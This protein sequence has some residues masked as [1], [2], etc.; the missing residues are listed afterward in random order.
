MALGK[1]KGLPSST[2]VDGRVNNSSMRYEI[3]DNPPWL[4]SIG[5]GFQVGQTQL[6]N[7]LLRSIGSVTRSVSMSRLKALVCTASPSK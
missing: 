1:D 4:Q 6:R 5:L 3:L 2:T 7:C